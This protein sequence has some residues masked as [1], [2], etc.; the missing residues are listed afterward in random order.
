MDNLPKTLPNKNLFL[1]ADEIDHLW[2]TFRQDPAMIAKYG[3]RNKP[4][5]PNPE[6]EEKYFKLIKPYFSLFI[7]ISEK[8]YGR[9]QVY[10]AICRQIEQKW[11]TFLLYTSEDK[12]F[13]IVDFN[14]EKLEE[15]HPFASNNIIIGDQSDEICSKLIKEISNDLNEIHKDLTNDLMQFVTEELE[16]SNPNKIHP[17]A[18][19]SEASNLVASFMSHILS[20]KKLNEE[21]DLEEVVDEFFEENHDLD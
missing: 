10:L 15:G 17:Q 20:R 13:M 9:R 21:V 7:N 11:E 19:L 3:Q 16:K 2:S 5:T 14:P 6:L 4:Y 1:T 8:G 18:Y 12:K